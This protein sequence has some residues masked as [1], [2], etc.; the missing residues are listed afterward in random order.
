MK[1]SQN[2]F[3]L[4]SMV[5]MVCLLFIQCQNKEMSGMKIEKKDFGKTKDGVSADLYSLTNANGMEVDITNYGGIITSIIVPDKDGNMG[6][7]ALGFDNL[8]DYMK[9]SPYFG[10]IVGRYG[11]R[12]AKGKFTLNGKTYTLAVNDG[13]NHLHGG[14]VGFDKVIWDAKEVRGGDYVGLKLSYLSKDGEEGYP[15]NLSVTVTYLLTNDNEIKIQYE[16]TTDQP[17]VCNLTNHT[18]FNLADGG[19]SSILDHEL[20]ID[21]DSITAIDET[22]IPTQLMPVAGTPFDFRKP[23]KIGLDINNDDPQIKNGQGYDH[24]FVLNGKS[25][26][27]RLAARAVDPSTG[28]VLEVLTEEPGIQL[29]TGNFLDGSIT[30]KEGKVYKYRNGFCLETQHYPD[31]PNQPDFPSTVLNPGEKYQTTTIYKFSVEK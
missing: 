27:L 19:A 28:R 10:C 17:T 11:N 13:P 29:Y 12:I 14:I 5:L 22:S 20:M 25:G 21:A 2:N 23:K 26:T 15:G 8:D 16:A 30:G 7:V 4:W 18:Y 3:I 24:N 6:D 9:K 1:R 31:S